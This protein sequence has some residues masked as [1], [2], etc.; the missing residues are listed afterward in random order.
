MKV[1]LFGVLLALR[2]SNPV[3]AYL[4]EHEH[5]QQVVTYDG[6]LQRYDRTAGYFQ[7]P[8]YQRAF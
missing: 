8:T 3:V 1:N 4:L 7:K 2:Y 6:D 5:V